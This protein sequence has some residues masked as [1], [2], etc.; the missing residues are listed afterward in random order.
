MM[1]L[2][3]KEGEIDTSDHC[4][5]VIEIELAAAGRS[6]IFGCPVDWWRR[7]SLRRES[8][9]AIREASFRLDRDRQCEI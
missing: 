1:D 9:D 3:T 5:P 4:W 6:R 7:K 8:E 2:E